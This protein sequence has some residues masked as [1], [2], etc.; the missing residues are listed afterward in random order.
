[1][2]KNPFRNRET[3]CWS[4]LYRSFLE[5]NWKAALDRKWEGQFQRE[6]REARFHKTARLPSTK[7]IETEY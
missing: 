5:T 1:M 3:L 6:M 2:T 4:E 7:I